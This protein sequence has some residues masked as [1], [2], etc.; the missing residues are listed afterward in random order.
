GDTFG[1]LFRAIYADVLTGRANPDP[2][3]A[4]FAAGHDEMLVNDAIGRSAAES[5][6]VDVDRTSLGGAGLPPAGAASP[7]FPVLSE[8]PS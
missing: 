3:Y 6:W 2:P 5:R 8:V 1:A 7:S 4:D